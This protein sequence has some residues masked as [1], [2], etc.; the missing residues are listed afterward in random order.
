MILF[1]CCWFEWQLASS[2][3]LLCVCVQAPFTWFI[4]CLTIMCF[5]CWSPCTVRRE[6]MTSWGPWGERA[7]QVSSPSQ[8]LEQAWPFLKDFTVKTV[9]N[10]TKS[11]SWL[12]TRLV[13]F[14]SYGPVFHLSVHTYSREGGGVQTDRNGPRLSITWILLSRSV[15]PLG[16]RLLSHVSHGGGVP[17]LHCS[18]RYHR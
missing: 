4:S 14:I 18:D 1:T 17:G 13:F 11:S 3:F 5:I 8:I 10:H 9:K 12:M 7:A 16:G 2:R 6:L 15:R